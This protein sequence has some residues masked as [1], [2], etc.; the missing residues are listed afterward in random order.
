[1]KKSEEKNAGAEACDGNS[2][3]QLVWDKQIN[4]NMKSKMQPV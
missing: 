2:T 3:I 1:M 4:S